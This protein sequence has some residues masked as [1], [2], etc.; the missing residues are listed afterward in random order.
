VLFFFFCGICFP[1]AGRVRERGRARERETPKLER[2]SFLLLF[3]RDTVIR[4]SL[5]RRPNAVPPRINQP[6]GVTANRAT[7]GEKRNAKT[8]PRV[9]ISSRQIISDGPTT[10]AAVS[11]PH[12]SAVP[13]PYKLRDF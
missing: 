12:S 11:T 9:K 7:G 8:R 5:W 1:R 2:F 10:V 6:D 3:A 4:G 13:P